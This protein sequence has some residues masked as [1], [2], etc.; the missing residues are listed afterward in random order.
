MKRNVITKVSVHVDIVD[1]FNFLSAN[2]ALV[3]YL[4]AL[5]KTR[6]GDPQFS[7]FFLESATPESWL[8]G[9][10]GWIATPQGHEFWDKLNAKWHNVLFEDLDPSEVTIKASGK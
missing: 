1:F 3:Q 2:N 8:S 10:F 7:K 6:A 5:H 4:N 9:A